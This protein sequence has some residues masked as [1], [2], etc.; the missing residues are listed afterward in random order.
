MD[1]SRDEASIPAFD[2]QTL[3]A[4]HRFVRRLAIG[5]AGDPDAADELT[6]RTLAA[7]V[8]QRPETGPGFRVWLARVARRLFLRERRERERRGRRERI[9]AT[10]EATRPTVD[11]VAE[12]ELHQRVALAFESL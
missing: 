11:L 2:P 5:L 3:V 6:A 10:G 8:E 7:A 1:A 12:I 9:A 4:H